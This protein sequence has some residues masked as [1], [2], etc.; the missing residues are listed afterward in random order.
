V[1]TFSDRIAWLHGPITQEPNG[2]VDPGIGN[3][4]DN[5]KNYG[6]VKS[7]PLTRVQIFPG[8]VLAYDEP[9]ITPDGAP[10]TATGPFTWGQVY[11]AG[12]Y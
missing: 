7:I 1:S 2:D 4:H 9:L 6:S 8:G 11:A 12:K 10:I 5:Y 3:A